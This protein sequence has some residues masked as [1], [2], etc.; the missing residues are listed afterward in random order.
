MRC[1]KLVDLDTFRPPAEGVTIGYPAASV[2]QPSMRL[3]LNRR[4]RPGEDKGPVRIS[5]MPEEI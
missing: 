4:M 5:N 3:H 1:L 2:T